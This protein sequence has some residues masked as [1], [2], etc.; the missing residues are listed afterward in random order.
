MTSR[1]AT[2]E[3]LSEQARQ[4]RDRGDAHSAEHLLT[5]AVER[6]PNDC[7]TRLELSE[8]LIE[9]GSTA[10]AAAHLKNLIG[11]NPDDPRGYVGLAEVLYHEQ[12]LNDADVV[13]DRALELDPRQARGLLLRGRIE[14][15]RRHDERAIEYYYQVLAV[16][17]DVVEARTL[18]AELHLAHGQAELAAPLLRSIADNASLGNDR[19]ARAQ[20]LLGRCYARDGRWTEAAASY[21]AGISSQRGTQQDWCELADACWHA[22]ETRAART[23]V[24]EALRVAP[25]DPRALA[26]YSA[27]VGEPAMGDPAGAT[28]TRLSHEP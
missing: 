6:N 24:N 2:A 23:A 17:P 22:G 16:D 10:A 13:L 12:K 4:A 7:E 8:M 18:I 19:R 21:V 9:R 3:R 26:L 1:S 20:W 14:Q 28:L 27:L 25:S 11:Q 15:A 5:A